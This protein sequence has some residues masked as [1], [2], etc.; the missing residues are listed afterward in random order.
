MILKQNKLNNFEPF[1]F[2]KNDLT[3]TATLRNFEQQKRTAGADT[4]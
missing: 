4:L 1:F 3:V 2:E